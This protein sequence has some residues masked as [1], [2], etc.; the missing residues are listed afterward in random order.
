MDYLPVQI[1]LD[2]LYITLIIG[3]V[4]VIFSFI[5]FKFVWLSNNEF[6]FLTNKER[7]KGPL[8]LFKFIKNQFIL[9]YYNLEDGIFWINNCGMEGYLY[10]LLLKMIISFL[11]Y[12][13]CFNLFYRFLNFLLVKITKSDDVQSYELKVIEYYMKNFFVIVLSFLVVSSIMNFRKQIK[14]IY[15]FYRRKYYRD[16]GYNFLLNRTVIIHSFK[17]IEEDDE[18]R[19]INELEQ[20][21]GKNKILAY[22]LLPDFKVSFRTFMSKTKR[23][24][25]FQFFHE[26]ILNKFTKKCYPSCVKTKKKFEKANKK[27]DNKIEKNLELKKSSYILMCLD[28]YKSIN[29]IIKDTKRKN[30]K[31]KNKFNKIRVKH[32]YKIRAFMHKNDIYWKHCYFQEMINTNCLTWEMFFILTILLIIIFLSTPTALYTYLIENIPGLQDYFTEVK[33]NSIITFYFLTLFLPGSITLGINKLILFIINRSSQRMRKLRLS[34]YH[35]TVF[36]KC[37]VYILINTLLIPGLIVSS[38]TNIYNIFH[39]SSGSSFTS[40]LKNF[41]ERKNITFFFI[42]ICQ[43]TYFSLF[44]VVSQ[45]GVLLHYYFSPGTYLKLRNNHEDTFYNYML[46]E[47]SCFNFGYYYSLNVTILGV[48]FIYSTSSILIVLFGIGYFS[49]RIFMD[50]YLLINI[51]KN[52][53]ESPGKLI[54]SVIKSILFILLL[55]QISV[56]IEGFSDM[57]FV[58]VIMISPLI[59]LTIYFTYL[60]SHI[61]LFDI[62]FFAKNEKISKYSKEDIEKWKK[63]H[64]HPFQDEFNRLLEIK[65]KKNEFDFKQNNSKYSENNSKDD[66]LD[67]III[68]EDK[69]ILLETNQ[70]KNHH[71]N[72]IVNQNAFRKP[73]F[74]FNR[75]DSEEKNLKEDEKNNNKTLNFNDQNNSLISPPVLDKSN[76]K[77]EFLNKIENKKNNLLFKEKIIMSSKKQKYFSSKKSKTNELIDCNYLSDKKT[78]KNKL[79][80]LSLNNSAE[81]IELEFENKSESNSDKEKN[82]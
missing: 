18:K 19:I 26:G 43:K 42:V 28:S 16:K 40:L 67:E 2:S 4:M 73:S 24:M 35:H 22:N 79:G 11:G 10:L 9:V 58:H 56:F 17:R 65:K 29:K 61:P 34:S 39:N 14:L 27:Y 74:I 7:L 54:H 3:S 59:I 48:V 78:K 57:N 41:F 76:K 46:R 6:V 71:I 75:K 68:K 8:G 20:S 23:K 25:Y 31:F 1:D 69:N 82:K 47:S 13:V 55:F 52:K 51:M 60:N 80:Y 66:I 72:I 45:I 38:G 81:L 15:I 70:E 63:G 53:I 37:F 50:S 49:M 30:C 36:K 77:K 62:N 64:R 44:G 12:Y 33:E 5:F 32:G 21:I